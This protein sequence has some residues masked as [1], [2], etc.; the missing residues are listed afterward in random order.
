MM[1]ALE[2]E[3]HERVLEVGTG[4]GYAA[5]VLGAM[6]HDGPKLSIPVLSRGQFALLA[7][8]LLVTAGAIYR[9]RART[10]SGRGPTG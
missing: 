6:A 2:L 10:G 8:A 5:A 4:S 1:E 3:G 7:A 9:L